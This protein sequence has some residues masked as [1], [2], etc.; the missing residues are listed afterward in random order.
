MGIIVWWN[1]IV[2]V[3]NVLTERMVCDE[4]SLGNTWILCT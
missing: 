2:K 4:F 3:S 1:K